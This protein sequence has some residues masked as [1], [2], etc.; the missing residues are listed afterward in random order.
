MVVPAIER[1]EH[2]VIAAHVDHLA[3]CA[4]L[5]EEGGVAWVAFDDV[6]AILR[7]RDDRRRRIDDVSQLPYLERAA[8]SRYLQPP[9]AETRL[10][11]ARRDFAPANKIDDPGG[12]VG[13]G[14]RTDIGPK[15][16]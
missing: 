13:C 1:M 6:I 9:V 12:R 7:R 8:A 5:G 3:A 14:P 2:A 16:P 10:F 11:G 15:R 4:V